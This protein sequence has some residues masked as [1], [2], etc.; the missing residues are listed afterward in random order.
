MVPKWQWDDYIIR[1]RTDYKEYALQCVEQGDNPEP[2]Y[3]FYK[4]SV[5]DTLYKKGVI[6]SRA[7]LLQALHE[8]NESPAQREIQ[9]PLD[10]ISRKPKSSRA[11]L[12]SAFNHTKAAVMSRVSDASHERSRHSLP[13]K[14]RRNLPTSVEK[15]IPSKINR[16]IPTAPI[17]VPRSG[18]STPQA[19]SHSRWSL[20]GAASSRASIEGDGPPRTGDQFRDFCFAFKRTTSMTGS[21]D[22]SSKER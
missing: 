16:S 11:S 8:L 1:N 18:R 20:D 19:G 5:Q 14:S 21:I 9:T 10:I 6:T 4:E 3:R 13:A 17:E 7:I 2:Y 12:P 22:V 15:A